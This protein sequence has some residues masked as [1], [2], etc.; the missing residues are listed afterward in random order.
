[1]VEIEEEAY[2]SSI[3]TEHFRHGFEGYLG[4]LG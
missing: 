3:A 4:N 1:M 2:L